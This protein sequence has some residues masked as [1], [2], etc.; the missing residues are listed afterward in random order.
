[1]EHSM[2]DILTQV[3]NDMAVLKQLLT[4]LNQRLERPEVKKED[5]LWTVNQ[6]ASYLHKSKGTIQSHYQGKPGFPRS[7]KIGNARYWKPAEIIAYARKD[8][9]Y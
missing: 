6:V 8:K 3:R 7:K 5:E 1:M 9:A 4:E 2:N